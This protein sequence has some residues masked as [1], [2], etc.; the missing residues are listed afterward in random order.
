MDS[1]KKYEINFVPILSY[2]QRKKRVKIFYRNKIMVLRKT[3]II[4]DVTFQLIE[5]M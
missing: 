2:I 5:E 4:L 1:K 3:L